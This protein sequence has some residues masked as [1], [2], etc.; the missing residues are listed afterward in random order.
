MMALIEIHATATAEL[1]VIEEK[2][3]QA[4]A[5]KERK[6]ALAIKINEFLSYF[7][8]LTDD[9]IKEI[10][11]GIAIYNDSMRRLD[12][13]AAEIATIKKEYAISDTPSST[14]P[15]EDGVRTVELE[16]KKAS[17]ELVIKQREYAELSEQVARIDELEE[18][19]A[20]LN[21]EYAE[22]ERRHDAIVKAKEHL[23]AAG[24]RL[25]AKYLGKTRAAFSELIT[26]LTGEDPDAFTMSVDFALTRSEV[27][28][29]RPT[30]ALSKGTQEIYAI[31]ARM[32]LISSLYDK[33][34]PFV[35]LDD[36]FC[37]LDDSRYSAAAAAMR[38]IS[39]KIQVIYLTC[40]DKRTI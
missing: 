5:D 11:Q 37:H 20:E 38:R 16:L 17:A 36:P 9:P 31:A 21:E 29:S 22:C 13:L 26:E 34:M 39:E 14:A 25:T 28:A 15:T 30:E 33:E 1:S 2:K 32:A 7:P 18:R 35:L 10:E 40:T 6:E 19:L 24:E 27:G 8:T 23:R 3:K 4:Q 12:E